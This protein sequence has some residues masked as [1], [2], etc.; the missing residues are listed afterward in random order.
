VKR[1]MLSVVT[2]GALC[3]Y[4]GNRKFGVM[5]LKFGVGDLLLRLSLPVDV[6]GGVTK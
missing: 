6:L 4:S 5:G 3:G 2:M 1:L